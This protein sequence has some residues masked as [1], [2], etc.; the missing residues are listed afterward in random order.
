MFI[1]A[2]ILAIVIG[3]LL[4]GRLKN[5]ES[6]KINWISLIFI[7]FFIEFAIVMLIQQ[8]II[9][10]GLITY[11]LNLVMYAILFTF[12]YKN[13]NNLYILIMGVG[14]LLN[15][16]PIFLNGG[17]MPVS[18]EAAQI[19]KLTM[20]IEKEGLYTLINN[21]TRFWYLGDIIPFIALRNYVVSIGDIVSALGIMFFII[22]S[23]KHEKRRIN[24]LYKDRNLSA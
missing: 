15:A 16:I 1:Y 9:N 23:M 24:E 11:S 10:R 14:F 18:S 13:R 12:I 8:G 19:A 17:A 6:V 20:N 4:K 2:I 5:F 3:Y 21:Q 22:T 7:S